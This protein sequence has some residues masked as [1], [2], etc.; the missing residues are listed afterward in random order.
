[1]N[2]VFHLVLGKNPPGK[3]TLDPKP[4]PIPNLTLTLPLTRL[5]RFFPEGFFPETLSTCLLHD[6]NF[7]IHNYRLSALQIP[8]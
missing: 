5:G 2:R 3:K 1:M 7:T 8:S 4:N 6:L